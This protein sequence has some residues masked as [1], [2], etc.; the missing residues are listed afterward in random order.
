M[1]RFFRNIRQK[2]A[3]ENNVA[4]YLR[5]A[6]GEIVL[7]VVG[8]LIALQINNWN[9]KRKQNELSTVYISRLVSDIKQ[10]T[11]NIQII[12]KQTEEAQEIIK[13]TIHILNTESDLPKTLHVLENYFEKGWDIRTFI[14]NDNTYTDLLQTGN[15][16]IL[17]ENI[18]V[19]DIIQYYA[20]AK[21][22]READLGNENWAVSIDIALT[23]KTSALEFDPVT[24]E[25]F[26]NKDK[27][28]SINHMIANK[29]LLER[30]AAAHYWY[31]N[32]SLQRLATI[33]NEA[34]KLLQILNSELE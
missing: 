20:S 32:S 17:K 9:E 11:L 18:K 22:S 19:E 12:K 23:E 1:I 27:Q 33:G 14:T 3:A 26:V 30:S 10:D 4:K 2:L 5:Y 7:V 24:R 34:H 21:N 16:S 8:I 6:I 15:M 31:N 25:L 29:E 28:V 13:N